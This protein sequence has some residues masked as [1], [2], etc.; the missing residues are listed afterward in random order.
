VKAAYLDIETNYVGTFADQRLFRDCKNHKITVIGVRILDGEKDAF[1]QFVGDEATREALLTVLSGAE[2]IV[3]YNGRSIPDN[4]KGYTGFD[5]PVIAAQLGV[6][7][8]KTF[9]HLDL[10]PACWRAGL[11]GGQK[12]I[13]EMLGLKRELPGKDGKWADDTWKNYQAT[14][15]E[16]FLKEL[17][18]YNREDVFMLRRIE[19]A[20]ERR[21]QKS[22]V[23]SW[24]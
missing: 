4:V 21:N 2:R 22:G 18:T 12:A 14:R 6:V 7:L 24:K 10:C 9:K 23:R 15:N 3:T 19:E 11:W 20:L 17:L 1:V 8:D 16:R 13:E 5:F